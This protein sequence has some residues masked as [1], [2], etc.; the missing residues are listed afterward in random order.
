[1]G[2]EGDVLGKKI[3]SHYCLLMPL[4]K[5]HPSYNFRFEPYLVNLAM[6]LDLILALF[7]FKNAISK[8]IFSTVTI[9]KTTCSFAFFRKTT[10]SFAPT[11]HS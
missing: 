6:Y 4:I 2:V 7:T 9:Y 3:N 1:M 11:E 8:T 5:I 10:R